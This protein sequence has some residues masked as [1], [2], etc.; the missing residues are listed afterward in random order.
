M[1]ARSN[2]CRTSLMIG[3][4][5]TFCVAGGAAASGAPSRN[6]ILGQTFPIAEP[7][8]LTEIQDAAK[9]R[10]WRSWM[11]KTPRDYAAFA[12]VTLPAA[13][14]STSRLFDPT[15]TL[16]MD[17]RDGSGKVLF[18]KG[19]KVNVYER[20]KLKM[21]GR[22]IVIS[23]GEAS[24]RWLDEVAKPAGADKI[25]LANGNVLETRVKTGRTLY[26]LDERFVERFGVRA[27][28]TIVTQEGTQLRVTEYALTR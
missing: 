20:L 10:D 18:P 23:P 22:F 8:A 26:R 4:L 6:V 17:L 14:R 3:L 11:R 16:P 13:S 24:L 5:M 27:V 15:Y 21:P 25:L 7:D 28:P 9:A 2:P 19:T 1:D 12:S